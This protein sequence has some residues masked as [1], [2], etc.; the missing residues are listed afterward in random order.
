MAEG[1]Q[2]GNYL[3]YTESQEE[4]KAYRLRGSVGSR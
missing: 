2:G 3:G 1:E 4:L